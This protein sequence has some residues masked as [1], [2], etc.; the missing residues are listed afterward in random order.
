[1]Y[2]C[3]R[4]SDIIIEKDIQ[5][6]TPECPVIISAGTGS[7]KSYFIKNIL[8]KYAKEHNQKILMLIHRTR[9]THE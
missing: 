9:Q 6:W 8:Y 4:I 2:K 5:T 1:M 3:K 7:G